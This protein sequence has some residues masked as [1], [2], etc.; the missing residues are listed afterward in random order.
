MYVITKEQY[1]WYCK[2]RPVE[3]PEETHVK[4]LKKTLAEYKLKDFSIVFL[5]PW[6]KDPS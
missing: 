3:F 4:D 5:Q 2:N 1:Y 6:L